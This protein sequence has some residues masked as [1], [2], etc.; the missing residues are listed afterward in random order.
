MCDTMVATPEVTGDGKMLFGKNSD[1]EPN[2]A[3]HLIMIPAADHP[4]GSL[5]K[6]TY[7]EIPQVRHTSAVLLAKPFWI[8]GAEM[9][10]NEHGV[11]IGNEAVFTK[12]PYEKN[13]S[14]IG[15]DLLRLGL[16][17]AETAQKALEV[18]ISL[19]ETYGQ[20]GNCGYQHPFFY[21]NSYLIADP[22]EAWVF[23]T[24]DRQWAAKRVA[25]IYTISNGLTIG[26]EW[27]LASPDLVEIAVK[28]GWCKG[29]DDFHFARCYSDTLYTNLS[30]CKGRCERSAALLSARKPDVKPQDVIR[31][32]RDH[33]SDQSDSW[34]PD[35]GL[36]GSNVCMHAGFGPVRASQTVGS[37]VSHLDSDLATHFFTGT[38]APCTSLFKPV[39]MDSGLPE[40]GPFP[41]GNFDP[42]TLFWRH[43]RLHR[44][45]L[46]DYPRRMK[47]YQAN[48][49]QLESKFIEQSFRLSSASK[50]ERAEFS[51]K[52]FQESDQAE[53]GWWEEIKSLEIQKKNGFLY[54]L[55]WSG[56]NR[57]SSIQV[58]SQ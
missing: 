35:R 18:M 10:V 27:D 5:V 12:M 39:W 29:R 19:L 40:M 42:D 30:N 8:W 17:R 20:G 32:L 47:V 16:E 46:L 43:E 1:R 25:G 15:M 28:R 11:A 41:D 45:T 22:R 3:H 38:A 36:T 51:A 14:M 33:G 52:T 37:M 2:E 9:G 56:F 6:L 57:S 4:E 23:E 13:E 58:G 34:R 50:A 49:D 54:S 53:T 24:A 26:G 44:E 55:A 21:H 48:R 7:I 31:T